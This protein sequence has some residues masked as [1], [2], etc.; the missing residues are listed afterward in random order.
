MGTDDAGG[1]W[2]LV[3]GLASATSAAYP[4]VVDSAAVDTTVR[5]DDN[6][7]VLMTQSNSRG[8]PWPH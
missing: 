1:C 4:A 8:Q 3:G 2:I 5:R 6:I 7:Y